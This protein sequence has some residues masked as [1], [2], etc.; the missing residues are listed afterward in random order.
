MIFN[1]K[2]PILGFENV[3]EFKFEKID[4]LFVK[5]TNAHESKP[6]FTLI[7]PYLLCEY[8]FDVPAPARIL[9][10]INEKSNI[11]I[12]NIV[13]VTNPVEHS[14]INFIAPLIFN[15][16][17]MTMGQVILDAYTYPQYSLAAKIE[18][19]FPNV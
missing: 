7:N 17:T 3:T 16:D 2:L 4:D 8:A 18:D 9:L 10:D 13:I 15:V 6:M 14:A 12:Y 11:L 1:V 19:F 5:I